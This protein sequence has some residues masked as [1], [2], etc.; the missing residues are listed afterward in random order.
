[1]RQDVADR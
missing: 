1:L